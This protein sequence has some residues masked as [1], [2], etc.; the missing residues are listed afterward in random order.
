MRPT[1]YEVA[2]AL[3]RLIVAG[4]IDIEQMRLAWRTIEDVPVRYH[5]IRFDGE[6]IV[7][8][9]LQLQ[10][11]N[12]YDAAYIALAQ[13]LNAELWTLDGPLARNASSLGFPVR[14]L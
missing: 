8:I 9:A 1:S 11:S 14:L 12:A 13:E 2:N 7:Q 6:S 5:S 4:E 10:R 3:T